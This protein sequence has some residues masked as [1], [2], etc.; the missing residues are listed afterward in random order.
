MHEKKQSKRRARRRWAMIGV[1]CLL[2]LA[3]CGQKGDLY[4]PGEGR[5]DPQQAG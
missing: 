4:L 3:A 1:A 2:L 5:A